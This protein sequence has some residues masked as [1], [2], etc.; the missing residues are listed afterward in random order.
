[1]DPDGCPSLE[2]EPLSTDE[3]KILANW[4]QHYQGDCVRLSAGG[5]E[6][7]TGAV[8]RAYFDFDQAAAALLAKEPGV[9]A[10]SLFLLLLSFYCSD[11][12][13]LAL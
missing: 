5:D 4:M 13:A 12:L 9:A 2:E 11:W 10:R 7:L 6:G 3:W 1:M 8:R